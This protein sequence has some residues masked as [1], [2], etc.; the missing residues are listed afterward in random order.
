MASNTDCFP[1]CL[2]NNREGNSKG[3]KTK[4][5]IHQKENKIKEKIK[6]TKHNP[7]G[8][9]SSRLEIVK[10]P[11]LPFLAQGSSACLDTAYCWDVFQVDVVEMHLT[12]CAFSAPSGDVP[13]DV[14][15]SLVTHTKHLRKHHV[16]L[17]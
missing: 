9:V 17:G 1:L 12:G 11:L 15:A 14:I 3:D 13:D 6:T 16:I 2:T 10:E 4:K 5:N 8:P 7:K